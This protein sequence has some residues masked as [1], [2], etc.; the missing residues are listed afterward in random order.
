MTIH[1]SKFARMI[2]YLF[3]FGLS[4]GLASIDAQPARAD[5]GPP[6]PPV[7][8]DL[9]PGDETTNVRML[10][11]HV[12]IDIAGY[13]S[14][15]SGH[16]NV[17]A[18]FNMRNIGEAEER[19]LVRFPMNHTSYDFDDELESRSEFCEF[20]PLPSISNLGVSV[21]GSKVDVEISYETM[22]DPFYS[23]ENENEVGRI[24]TFPCWAHFWVTFPPDQDVVVKI[25]YIVPGYGYQGDGL[26]GEGFGNVE[27][28]YILKTGEGWMDTIGKADIVARLPYD[29]DPL[30][31]AECSPDDCSNSGREI[32]WH[33]EDFEPDE[34]IDIRIMRP[35]IWQRV[36]KER[37]NIENNPQDGEAW[38]RLARAYKES[39]L[40]NHL[41]ISIYE[42]RELE[43]FSLSQA[44]YQKAISLLPDDADWRF[45]FA[46]LLC[47]RAF[48]TEGTDNDWIACVELL[49]QTLEID[50][51]HERANSL[52]I[53]IA[54][55]R[56]GELK[57]VDL[58]GPE[59]DYLILTPRPSPTVTATQTPTPT[60]TQTAASTRQPDKTATPA[61]THTPARFGAN[62]TLT[63]APAPQTAS[64]GATQTVLA[65]LGG[66]L[67]L[68][69]VAA[70]GLRLRR[71]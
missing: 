20:S 24:V 14:Y 45:G 6:P 52:L 67:V 69:V 22:I 43:L 31:F 42:D 33:F 50:P 44:A 7:G 40:A 60:R 9:F 3:V 64:P 29:V 16:A 51:E 48:W 53:N 35:E 1:P 30:N 28:M 23:P 41:R 37:Q 36:L 65:G 26:F 55:W 4:A 63:A 49:K 39:I 56:T 54:E 27:Y 18:V 25:T 47:N 66:L 19:M 13:S 61:A 70:V 62:P 8:S 12:T 32:S 2:V 46:D 59:P 57:I 15:S 11:E 58:T 17:T 38:G 71:G 10:S 5:V 21:D 34:D 68:I